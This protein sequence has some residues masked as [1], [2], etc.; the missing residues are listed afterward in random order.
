MLTLNDLVSNFSN[1]RDLGDGI[2]G[3]RDVLPKVTYYYYLKFADS[4]IGQCD[5]LVVSE[6]IEDDGFAAFVLGSA[7]NSFDKNKLVLSGLSGN[8]RGFTDFLMAPPEFHSYFKGRLDAKRGNLVL[9]LPIF[10]SEFSGNETIDEFY[11]LRKNIV[12]TLDWDRS[13]CPKIRIR[14]DNPKSRS[15]TGD[16]YILEKY[17][18]V[19]KEVDN[20]E[21]VFDGYMEIVNYKDIVVEIISKGDGIFSLIR[22]RDDTN[23]ELFENAKLKAWLWSFLTGN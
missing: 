1:V 23:F 5:F 22:N 17:D 18:F 2:I 14:F 16:D 7:A 12:P 11:Y 10:R 6:N 19:E 9:R 4:N 21:G 8:G 13:V 20:L 3:F 15:G